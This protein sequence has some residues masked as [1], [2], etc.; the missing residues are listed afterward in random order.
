M[1]TLFK[2]KGNHIK[3]FKQVDNWLLSHC[4]TIDD[5]KT[6]DGIG[7]YKDYIVFPLKDNKYCIVVSLDKMHKIKQ[8]IILLD[9]DL[10]N[11]IQIHKWLLKKESVYGK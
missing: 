10:I 5:H 9:S 2:V 6:L 11:E 1:K 4:I 7:N 3:V 8:R